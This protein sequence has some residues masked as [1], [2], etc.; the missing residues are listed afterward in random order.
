MERR[1]VEQERDTSRNQHP[2]AQENLDHLGEGFLCRVN[3]TAPSA[4]LEITVNCIV[5]STLLACFVDG[6]EFN[7]TLDYSILI[8]FGTFQQVDRLQIPCT[9]RPFLCVPLAKP[10]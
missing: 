3:Q 4:T 10:L 2:F 7:T 9:P 8:T 1:Q 6:R 5:N